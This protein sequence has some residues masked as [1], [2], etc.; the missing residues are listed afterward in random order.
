[1]TPGSC[2]CPAQLTPA[3][4]GRLRKPFVDLGGLD[5][6]L[7]RHGV[8]RSS[9]DPRADRNLARSIFL[10][11]GFAGEAFRTT[12]IVSSFLIFWQVDRNVPSIWF[13]LN[14]DGRAPLLPMFADMVVAVS[15]LSVQGQR[16]P[17][18][19]RKRKLRPFPR[20]IQCAT[21]ELRF[22]SSS[23]LA[24]ASDTNFG[25]KGSSGNIG[26]SCGFEFEVPMTKPQRH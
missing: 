13:S 7:G 21:P 6:S 1:M 17:F 9:A 12:G 10:G 11:L 18:S 24:A 22:R 25:I 23:A 26:F 3:R 16:P 15:W 19:M 2:A 5:H 4:F 20:E 14:H 8:K